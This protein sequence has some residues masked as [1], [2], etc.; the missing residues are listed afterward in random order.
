M[1]KLHIYIAAPFSSDQ[2]ANTGIAIEFG[3]WLIDQGYNVYIP[4]LSILQHMA[5]PRSYEEWLRLTLEWM[6]RCDCVIRLPG[7]SKGASL[8]AQEARG[9]NIPLFEGVADDPNMRHRV[10][11]WLEDLQESKEVASAS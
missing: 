4:H 3:N 2:S 10:L 6:L 11:N 9:R 5:K 7:F 1:S 8:E